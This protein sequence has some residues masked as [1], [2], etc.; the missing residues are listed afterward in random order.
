[1]IDLSEVRDL[2]GTNKCFKP[3]AVDIAIGYQTMSL[4]GLTESP[5]DY[6][7]GPAVSKKLIIRYAVKLLCLFCPIPANPILMWPDQP[8]MVRAAAVR[9]PYFYR[10]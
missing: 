3:I 5:R 2:G 1:M 6:V 7:R 4:H 8:G 10:E 9:D